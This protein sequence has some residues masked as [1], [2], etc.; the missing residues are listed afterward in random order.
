MKE[1]S[2]I[3][4]QNKLRSDDQKSTLELNYITK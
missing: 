2:M 3:I 1:N 4:P